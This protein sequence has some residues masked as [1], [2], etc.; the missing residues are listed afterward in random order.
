MRA[1]TFK[2]R[3][4]NQVHN[5]GMREALRAVVCEGGPERNIENSGH[6]ACAWPHAADEH[7]CMH[8]AHTCTR[9]RTR[10]CA[11]TQS[12]AFEQ[13]GKVY[14]PSKIRERAARLLSHMYSGFA[15]PPGVP[16]AMRLLV[17][18]GGSYLPLRATRL[19]PACARASTGVSFLNFISTMCLTGILLPETS[20]FFRSAAQLMQGARSLKLDDY[21]YNP[22]TSGEPFPNTVNPTLVHL[23]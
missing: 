6:L 17:R 5:E 3:L 22:R 14:T 2:S 7:A 9:K 16:M 1:I 10:A 13:A 12:H 4:V 18:A 20:G 19:S 8:G 15:W 11:R 23:Y 21:E